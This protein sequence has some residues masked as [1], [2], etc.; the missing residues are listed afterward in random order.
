MTGFKGL[1]RMSKKLEKKASKL[2][3]KAENRATVIRRAVRE[4][5]DVAQASA[6]VNPSDQLN[7]QREIERAVV[8]YNEVHKAI[9][10]LRK[11]IALKSRQPQTSALAG[12]KYSR[13]K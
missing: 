10:R 1:Y 6:L 12:M 11:K 3:R 8:R 9:K 2:V 7:G 5:N 4:Y 13:P